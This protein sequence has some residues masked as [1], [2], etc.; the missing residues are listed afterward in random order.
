MMSHLP[1][2]VMLQETKQELTPIQTIHIKKANGQNLLWVTGDGMVKVMISF[3]GQVYTHQIRYNRE[4]S[5]G[6]LNTLFAG[7]FT[8]SSTKKQKQ[9]CYCDVIISELT[10]TIISFINCMLIRMP[11]R[12][13]FVLLF[14]F[15]W[16]DIV[17]ILTTM[18]CNKQCV[19]VII[20]FYFI[21]YDR[22]VT[23]VHNFTFYISFILCKDMCRFR[24]Y[25]A[26]T[27]A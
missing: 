1:R 18:D 9:Y 14:Q 8:G 16:N 6:N 27:I 13:Q 11:N 15:I 12:L 5:A 25:L 24:F 19:N 21:N 4:F 22:D 10:L 23:M 7:F 3:S 17:T 20:V 2:T 26:R